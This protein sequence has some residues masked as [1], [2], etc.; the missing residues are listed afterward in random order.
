MLIIIGFCIGSAAFGEVAINDAKLSAWKN[1]IKA[2]EQAIATRLVEAPKGRFYAVTVPDTLDLAD[3]AS[4]G[5]NCLTGALDPGYGYELYFGVQFKAKPP[6]MHHEASGLPTNNPKFAESMPMMRLMSGSAQNLDIQ[7]GMMLRTLALIADD[8]LYYAPIIGRP[9]HQTW[10]RADDDFAN[11]YG[12]G[13]LLLALLAWHQYDNNPMWMEYAKRIVNGLR[14]IA[15]VDGEMA[16]FPDPKIGESFSYPKSGYPSDLP[17]PSDSVFGIHMYFS[18]VMRGLA[19]YAEMTGDKDTLEFTRKLINFVRQPKMWG[20]N[21]ET[22]GISG[23]EK[24]H[25][26]GHFHAHVASLRGLLEYAIVANDVNL[27]EFVRNGYEYAR[28]FGIAEIGWFPENASTGQHCESCCIA[29]M[30]AL[31]VKLSDA[32]VGDYWEDV[33]RYVRNQLVEQQFVSKD[34]LQK[35]GA[36]MPTRKVTPPTE[37]DDRVIE[38]NIGG[39]AGYGDISVL[40]NSW[41]M[42]CCTGNA[43]QA[44]YYAWDGIVRKSGKDSVQINLLLNRASP[45]LDIDSYLP[46]EGKVLIVNKTAKSVSIRIP[47]WVS[48]G[49]VSCIVGS[50]RVEANWVGNYILFGDLKPGNK[51]KLAFPVVERS[52]IATLEGITYKLDFR[53][54]TLI[55]HSILHKEQGSEI[56]D[57]KMLLFGTHMGIVNGLTVK[58]VKVNVDAKSNSECGI[59]LQYKDPGNFLLAMYNGQSIYFH[60]VVGGNYGA[61]LD[62]ASVHDLAENIK[63]TAEVVGS[64]AAFTV[65]DGTESFTVKHNII[66]AYKAGSVGVFHNKAA[67]QTLDNFR[68]S[69]L[70]GKMLMEDEF[71]SLDISAKDWTIVNWS[72]PGAIDGKDDY[73]IY[74]RSQMRS[75]KAPMTKKMR[76]VLDRHING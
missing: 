36:S 66:N 65:T 51:I 42:H 34:L 43:T 62:N 76:Y 54:N 45:W 70:N 38:R 39:F 23:A 6:Y 22:P 25:F 31:A 75:N 24:G 63:L 55:D 2:K 16:Y 29:D 73:P 60:E 11:I 61:T 17:A 71:N 40:P 26:S 64:N 44:L 1:V 10:N 18:G 50:K 49:A 21:P 41:I 35:V 12:N 5:I 33:D 15:R 46:Y 19:K 47:S 56:R 4:L 28:N 14:K 13:R 48:R 72:N 74:Q 52:S 37:T 53:G 32:G 27:K 69:D 58:N 68:V 57:G 59:I 8:G 7:R 67:V 3:R 20:V 30:V 9:W